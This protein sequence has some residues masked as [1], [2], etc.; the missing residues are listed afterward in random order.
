[1]PDH[2]RGRAAPPAPTGRA[3]AHRHRPGR[4][5]A[6][7]ARPGRRRAA[8]DALR[9]RRPDGRAQGPCGIGERAHFIATKARVVGN[10]GQVLQH[11]VVQGEGQGRV[12]RRPDVGQLQAN[13]RKAPPDIGIGRVAMDQRID[14][15]KATLEWRDCVVG[16]PRARPTGLAQDLPFGSERQDDAVGLTHGPVARGARRFDAAA[17]R[18][19][20]RARRRAPRGHGGSMPMSSAPACSRAVGPSPARARS[21]PRWVSRSASVWLRSIRKRL[22][23]L[24]RVMRA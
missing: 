5:L 18:E 23:T 15:T 10:L 16:A 21:M 8:S 20:R 7:A 19:S 17:P 9:P 11:V 6:R 24:L 3:T 13:G 2:R 1:M 14:Q 22:P 12:H 4:P